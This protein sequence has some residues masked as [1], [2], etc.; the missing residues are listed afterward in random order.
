MGCPGPWPLYPPK[1]LACQGENQA[2]CAI[3]TLLGINPSAPLWLPEALPAEWQVCP[4]LGPARACAAS[5][6]SRWFAPPL[7]IL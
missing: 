7:S 1:W 5:G 3:Y 6:F 2:P 4:L